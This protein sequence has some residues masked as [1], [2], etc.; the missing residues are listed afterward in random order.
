MSDSPESFN[1]KDYRLILICVA[2]AITS[3]WIATRF[4]N[5]V[6]P[7]ASIEFKVNRESSLPIALGF[8]DRLNPSSASLRTASSIPNLQNYRHA[9]IFDY[10]DTAKT[11]LERQFGLERANQLMGSEIRLW[12]WSHR[13]FRPQQ[14]EEF[15][16]D[17]SPRGE[18]TGFAHLVDENAEGANLN[19]EE[20]R[21]LAER[22][23]QQVVGKDLSE[24]DFIEVHSE[25]REKRTD[26]LFRWKSRQLQLGDAQYRYSVTVQGNEIGTYDEDLR[27]P[28]EWLRGYAKLRSQNDITSVVAFI[29]LAATALAM[30]VV[31]V[32]NI[33]HRDIPWRFSG[34]LGLTG[35]FLTLLS[36]LNS[37]P[38]SEFQFR[39]TDTY[40]SFL[41]R[42]LL[43][44][45]VTAGGSGAL[46]FLITAC[47][48]PIYRQA[49]PDRIALPH[50]FRWSGIRSK[51]F[52][53]GAII[54]LTLTFF[55]FAYDSVFYLV[56]NHFG[57][58]APAEVPYTDLLNTRIP[59]AFVLFFGFFPAIS[60]EFISRAFSVP[61]FQQMFRLRWVAVLLASFIWGFAHANYPN[62]PFYIRGIEVGIGGLIVSWIFIRFGIVGPLVWHYSVDAFYTAFLLLRS[63]N[64]YLT[65]SG[66]LSAGIMLIPLLIALM[67]YLKH[68]GFV[69]SRDFLNSRAD[70]GTSQE[71]Q[72]P[73]PKDQPSLAYVPL[74]TRGRVALVSL[75][76]F[77]LA[78]SLWPVS[79]FGSFLDVAISRSEALRTAEQFMEQRGVT[80]R[81][82]QTIVYY[83]QYL[84]D[85][86]AAQYLLK[87]S[88]PDTLNQIYS[89]KVKVAS[90]VARFFHPLEEEEFWVFID[91]HTGKTFTFTHKLSENAPGASLSRSEAQR[92]AESFLQ[93]QGISSDQIDLKEV[94]SEKR[95]AR[96]DHSFEW[97]MREGRIGQSS[98]RID[99]E[100][101][102]SQI[103]GFSSYVKVPEE[104][105]RARKKTTFLQI[106]VYGARF[107]VIGFLG[108]WAFWV[109]LRNARKGQIPWKSVLTTSLGLVLLQILEQMNAIPVL[110]RD[111]KTSVAPRIFVADVVSE[112]VISQIL[113]LLFFSFLIG[114]V[115]SLYPECQ[116]IWQRRSRHRYITDALWMAILLP[117]TACGVATIEAWL[118][119]H[120]HQY[121]LLPH[122]PFLEEINHSVPAFSAFVRA[123]QA[124]VIYPSVFCIYQFVI[125]KALDKKGARLLFLFLTLVSLL[126]ST[127]VAKGEWLFAMTTRAVLLML[128]LIVARFL[129]RNNLLAYFSTVF[130]LVLSR[131]AYELISQTSFNLKWNGAFLILVVLLFLLKLARDSRIQN[132]YAVSDTL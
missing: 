59:W 78:A 60:E 89:Q 57:A 109:F 130:V 42:L 71:L 46:I 108:G 24:L 52:F 114:V 29:F 50:L 98:I 26:H 21:T 106:L 6:F 92:I 55:F 95:K 10:D 77:F 122:L 25:K 94:N 79:R 65:V 131:S 123:V 112:F 101:C 73:S 35:F 39:T 54:G 51:E 27:V 23:L 33:P 38:L 126:P 56:A 12:H 61:F 75:C 82:F 32:R 84:D 129:A 81:S 44:A 91:P 107:L 49:Y 132:R 124:S 90:W 110:F 9:A 76:L 5:R 69:Y 16:V 68:R 4:F 31:L 22:F 15:Q 11:F 70:E 97:E 2:V 87:Y 93:A 14:K 88:G 3:L 63:K 8:L 119:Q 47:T 62:Q 30:V 48:E 72:I 37:L 66:G 36:Q 104:W 100:L 58:W 128:V 111:Y 99:V 96:Q 115:F 116:A 121:A 1:R 43:Q 83:Q 17:V 34:Y 113:Q 117:A 118:I 18:V 127:P 80:W 67:A 86:L 105:E 40:G 120:L 125:C 45:L 19:R 103:T 102:G 74:T 41:I 28:E 7:E 53:I 20:A 64:L 85:P 13:W